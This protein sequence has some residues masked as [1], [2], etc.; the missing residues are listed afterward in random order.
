MFG[1]LT[2]EAIPYH[3][4]I[5]MGATVLMAI[6]ALGTVAALTNFGKWGWLWREY[7]TST[8]HKRI[9]VM[10]LVVA[11]L[12]LVRGFVDAVMMRAQQAVAFDSPGFLPAHHFD[13]I[14]SAHGTIMIF[15][16]AIAL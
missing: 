10:Y 9:G 8:D 5:I 13:Q 1:K 6:M 7:L 15:F 11:G 3:E 16:M 12:M 4:P 14:F 2:L